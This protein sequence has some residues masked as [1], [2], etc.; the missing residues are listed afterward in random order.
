MPSEKDKILELEQYRK[1]DKI[2]R[3]FMLILNR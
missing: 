3:I 2:P 1:S